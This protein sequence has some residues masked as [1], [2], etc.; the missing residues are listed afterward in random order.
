MPLFNFSLFAFLP[1][2][3]RSRLS[4]R[5]H[6]QSIGFNHRNP[7]WLWLGYFDKS[8]WFLLNISK[9]AAA[10]VDRESQEKFRLKNLQKIKKRKSKRNRKRKKTRRWCGRCPMSCHHS[11]TWPPRH[12]ARLFPF[13]FVFVFLAVRCATVTSLPAADQKQT[14]SRSRS[15]S[16]SSY[17]LER[18]IITSDAQSSDSRASIERRLRRFFAQLVVALIW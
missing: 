5:N 11:R 9:S 17:S 7:N 14:R 15:N 3:T 2:K 1:L 4:E 8:S 10:S 6:L 18:P 13:F 12:A 16:S